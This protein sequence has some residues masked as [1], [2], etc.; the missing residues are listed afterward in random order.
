MIFH[1]NTSWLSIANFRGEIEVRALPHEKCYRK[2]TVPHFEKV[3]QINADYP[4]ATAI[5]GQHGVNY[6]ITGY[7]NRKSALRVLNKP[8][9]AAA[10]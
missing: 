10:L 5:G 9:T 3:T 1:K 7:K 8:Q 2:E 6:R 4:I